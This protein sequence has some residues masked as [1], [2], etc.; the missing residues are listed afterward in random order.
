[1]R[2]LT[3]D[4]NVSAHLID[5][6][7]SLQEI[8]EPLK[9]RLSEVDKSIV[10][11]LS[12]GIPLL[13]ESALHLFSKGGKR[14]RA[15]LVLLTSGLYGKDPQ[16]VT[17]LAA[18]AEIV[19]AATLVHDDIIDQAIVRR[20]L[21]SV[22]KKFGEKAAVLA[23]DYMYTKGLNAAI[24]YGV[25]A[26]FPVMVS[27]TGDMVKGELYQLQYSNI[28]AITEEHYYNIIELKTARFMGTCTK[29]G[30]IMGGLSETECENMRLYGLKIGLAFQIID[31]TLDIV[32][33]EGTTGKDSANDFL[34]GKITLPFIYFLNNTSEKEKAEIIAIM[35]NPSLE[36]WNAIKKRIVETGGIEYATKAAEKLV[37]EACSILLPFPESKSKTILDEIAAFI[38]DRDF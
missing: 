31:D 38:V 33:D 37:N 23:G 1:M 8:T 15:A 7:K 14:I 22:S 24:E 27:G 25:P 28:D 16:G 12:T 19:H 5:M 18:A 6:G 32:E 4:V 26:I 34:D 11:Q 9:S 35:K 36:K 30:A 21:P 3:Q 17:E 2:Y 10:A 20:G 29:I 13:D